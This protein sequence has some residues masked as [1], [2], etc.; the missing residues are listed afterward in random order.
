MQL[1][2]HFVFILCVDGVVEVV[3]VDIFYIVSFWYS[4]F[5]WHFGRNG[6]GYLNVG[7]AFVMR[8]DAFFHGVFTFIARD[9][10]D[11]NLLVASIVCFFFGGGS[12][13]NSKSSMRTG[14]ECRKKE[15]KLISTAYRLHGT[16]DSER[17]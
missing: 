3:E 8:F 6:N 11:S 5:R 4:V 7:L 9:F 13:S 1:S 17:H 12:R 2:R 15:R 10:Q 14:F 16:D